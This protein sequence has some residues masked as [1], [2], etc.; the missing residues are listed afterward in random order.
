MKKFI[1]GLMLLLSVQAEA[2]QYF[3]K[4]AQI[5]FFS[6]TPLEDIEAVN[7]KAVGVI[8][9][10]SADLEFSVLLKGFEFRKALMQNHFNE[11]YVES[12]KYP[13]A[14]FKGKLLGPVVW[15]TDGVYKSDVAGTLTLHGVTQP[16]K[17]TATITI[18][19]GVIGGTA[20]MVIVLEDYKIKVPALAQA[21][22]SKTIAVNISVA[23][24]SLLK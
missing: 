7:K 21:N 2:Q 16:Q 4:E 18:K 17:A 13:K 11:N 12:D 8:N 10:M 20:D 14:T 1:V 5:R 23:A 3:T 9:T 6:K 15:T 22:I 24:F 19:N